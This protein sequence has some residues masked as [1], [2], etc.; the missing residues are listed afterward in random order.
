MLSETT[1]TPVF[2]FGVVGVLVGVPTVIMLVAHV[3][4]DFLIWFE[5]L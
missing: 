2:I 4:A 1:I 5:G 3:I